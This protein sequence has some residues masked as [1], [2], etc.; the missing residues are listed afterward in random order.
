MK[1]SWYRTP[2]MLRDCTFDGSSGPSFRRGFDRQDRLVMAVGA[3][4][5]VALLFIVLVLEKLP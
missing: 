4:A 5:F 3:V 1:G 2:R